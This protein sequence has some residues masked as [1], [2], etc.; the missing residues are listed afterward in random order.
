[1]VTSG[2]NIILTA[3]LQKIFLNIVPLH[4]ERSGLVSLQ[5]N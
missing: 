2:S 1:L 5:K 3:V 4:L